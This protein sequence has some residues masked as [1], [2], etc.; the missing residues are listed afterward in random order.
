[1]LVRIIFFMLVFLGLGADVFGAND[2]E[3]DVHGVDFR[4]TDVHGTDVHGADVHGVDVHGVDV[5][6]ADDPS[7]DDPSADDLLKE[8]DILMEVPENQ[9][10]EPPDTVFGQFSRHLDL[11][12]S[13]TFARYRVSSAHNA[14]ETGEIQLRYNTWAGGGNFSFHL[15]GWAELGTQSDTYKGI[16]PVFQDTRRERNILELKQ[17]YALV[18][19]DGLGL[20]LGR[21]IQPNNTNAIV[22]VS[23]VY[24]PLDLNIPVDYRVMGVWQVSLDTHPGNHTTVQASVFP[25]FQD[26]KIPGVT[27]RWMRVTPSRSYWYS[28]ELKIDDIRRFESMDRGKAFLLYYYGDLLENSRVLQNRLTNKTVVMQNDRPGSNWE[29]IGYYGLIKTSVGRLDLFGSIFHGPN[30]FPL[31]YVEDRGSEIALIRKNPGV[32][33]F[34]GGGTYTWKNLEFH[35]EML[36]NL[37]SANKDDDYFAYTG[38][39]TISDPRSASLLGIENVLWR[40]DYAGEMVTSRQAA[41]GYYLSSQRIRPF[42]DDL[43]L[44]LLLRVNPSFSVYYN[45][46]LDFGHN[47]Q[48]HKLGGNYQLNWGLNLDISVEFFDGDNS[49]FIGLWR[50]NDRINCQ[51]SYRF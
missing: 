38:G 30:P 46:D 20:T 45:M 24:H 7:A 51:L 16:S 40:I 13:T 33:R 42:T 3:A 50:D 5:H 36:Y 29:E 8:L 15:D 37:S 26:H 1:M 48:Y 22:P 14:D 10:E 31:L 27:S 11:T 41:P 35:S 43:L 25:V 4:G 44:H 47:A 34:S 12:L 9:A 32:T 17:V 18:D 39:V 21:K 49:S 28:D 19:I 23:Q 2:P 6:G